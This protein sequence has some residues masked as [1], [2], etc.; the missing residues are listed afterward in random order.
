M[1]HPQP[2]RPELRAMVMI[3]LVVSGIWALVELAQYVIEGDPHHLDRAI[4]LALRSPTDLDDP[5]GPRWFEEMVRDYTAFGAVGVLTFIVLAA[6]GFML[7]QGK[8]R[9]TLLIG[10]A[11]VGALVLNSLLKFGFDRPRPDL[12]A[13]MAYTISPSFPSG[14]AL[15]AAATYLT[16]GALLARGQP[17]RVLKAYLFLLAAVLTFIVGFSRVYLGV[18]WPSDVLAGWTIGGLWALVCCLMA[19]RLQ[20]IGRVDRR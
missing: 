10:V 3:L 16:I 11:F 18:H 8:Y 7:L 2:W 9:S 6:I 5:I 20:R 15:L 1:K 12:V 14:H 4:L 17:N 13:P 19:S